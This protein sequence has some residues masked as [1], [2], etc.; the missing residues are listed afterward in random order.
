M[1]L[2]KRVGEAGPV[3]SVV[4]GGGFS[5]QPIPLFFTSHPNGGP[6]TDHGGMLATAALT[7]G[8]TTPLAMV[9]PGTYAAMGQYTTYLSYHHMPHALV[10]GAW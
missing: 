6:V 7:A 4:P 8:L 2:V 10:V 3:L 9:S 5:A 1:K